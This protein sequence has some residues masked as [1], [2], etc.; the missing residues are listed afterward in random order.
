MSSFHKRL[1]QTLV[2]HREAAA[3]RPGKTW[4]DRS[5]WDS[6]GPGHDSPPPHVVSLRCGPFSRSPRLWASG[7][8]ASPA[9]AP[10]MPFSSC[11]GV[12]GVSFDMAVTAVYQALRSGHDCCSGYSRS[13]YRAGR[14]RN[15]RSICIGSRS[16]SS[17]TG[18][19][20]PWPRTKLTWSGQSN[21]AIRALLGPAR[22]GASVL[23]WHVDA[24]ARQEAVI[25]ACRHVASPAFVAAVCFAFFC[26]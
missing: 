23:G 18:E 2:R 6:R 9:T 3:C 5:R 24:V 12:L 10:V 20:D 8:S 17:F 16:A 1:R 21:P 4:G 11:H 25:H 22:S 13:K 19:G 26:Q 14:C 7:V 15:G